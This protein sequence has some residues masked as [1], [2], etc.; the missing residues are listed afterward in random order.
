MGTHWLN[1]SL[2]IT[3]LHSA[4]LPGEIEFNGGYYSFKRDIDEPTHLRGR[5]AKVGM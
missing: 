3:L 4:D 5:V 2:L 1:V